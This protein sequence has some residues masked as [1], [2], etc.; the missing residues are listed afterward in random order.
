M[1][2]ETPPPG[3]RY[4]SHLTLLAETNEGWRNLVKLVSKGHLEG[5]SHEP[6]VDKE[7]L[8]QHSRGLICLSGSLE[9]E[10]NELIL[11]GREDEARKSVAFFLDV[12]G[13]DNFF[14]Q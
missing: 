1:H 5:G 14:L 3:R 10:I 6:R 4:A 9:G 7:F 11:S 13:A 2:E 8:S 12:F